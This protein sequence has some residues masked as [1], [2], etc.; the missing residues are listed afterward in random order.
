MAARALWD[1]VHR[2]AASPEW[3]CQSRSLSDMRNLP[4]GATKMKGYVRSVRSAPVSSRH[5]PVAT[6]HTWGR[7][8]S[9]TRF[10]VSV[11]AITSMSPF[12]RAVVVG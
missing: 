10:A 4:F 5:V 9:P 8:F 11:P 3:E 7:R 12:G 2:C 6:C 1:A